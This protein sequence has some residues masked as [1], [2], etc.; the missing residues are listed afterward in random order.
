MADTTPTG[1]ADNGAPNEAEH[2]CEQVKEDGNRSSDPQAQQ[3]HAG[4]SQ[5]RSTSGRK[6]L[7]GT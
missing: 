3:S 6:P 5:Q 4:L 1:A 2:A 7:F